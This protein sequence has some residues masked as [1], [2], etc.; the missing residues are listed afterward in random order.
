MPRYDSSL[1]TAYAAYLVEFRR[2]PLEVVRCFM[3]QLSDFQPTVEIMTD[4]MFELWF[5]RLKI[6]N[7]TGYTMVKHGGMPIG[8]RTQIDREWEQWSNDK[9]RSSSSGASTIFNWNDGHLDDS[10][11]SARSSGLWDDGQS[12]SSWDSLSS[13]THSSTKSPSSHQDNCSSRISLSTG[14]SRR[15]RRRSTS[16]RGSGCWSA[17]VN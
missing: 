1:A 16:W 9:S 15:Q 6:I 2:E 8:L 5:R 13:R 3:S 11:G 17:C 12:C 7:E 10:R 14:R 4:S